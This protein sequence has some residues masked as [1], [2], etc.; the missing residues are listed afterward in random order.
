MHIA[1]GFGHSANIFGCNINEYRHLTYRIQFCQWNNFTD[2]TPYDADNIS[3][4]Y[5]AAKDSVLFSHKILFI[6]KYLQY[7]GIG[8]NNGIKLYNHGQNGV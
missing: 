8:S 4:M 7:T 3:S 1:D 5:R 2:G 6:W